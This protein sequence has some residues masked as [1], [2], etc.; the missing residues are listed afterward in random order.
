MN[1]NIFYTPGLP[2]EMIESSAA[3]PFHFDTDP[4]LN[5]KVLLKKKE[6]YFTKKIHI[7]NI[8]SNAKMLITFTY[9]EKKR[10]FV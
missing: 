6:S 1:S 5:R 7:E 9:D 8:N 10:V 2:S 3:D 4:A